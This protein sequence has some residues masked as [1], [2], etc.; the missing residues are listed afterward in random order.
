MMV[1]KV[2]KR[3][4]VLIESLDKVLIMTPGAQL[5]DIT[6]VQLFNYQFGV[7]KSTIELSFEKL[8]DINEKMDFIT[9][10]YQES[11]NLDMN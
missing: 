1:F 8:L 5:F 3:E 10:I 2:F 7:E 11:N 6:F 9:F 4:N